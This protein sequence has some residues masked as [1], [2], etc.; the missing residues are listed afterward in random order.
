MLVRLV[1]WVFIRRLL[2]RQ[3]AQ[4]AP[5]AS[6]KSLPGKVHVILAPQVRFAVIPRA[7]HARKVHSAPLARLL[8]PY[9][10]R[11]SI[12]RALGS[13]FATTALLASIRRLPARQ[14]ALNV[15]VER[16]CKLRARSRMFV[17][18][19]H[20]GSILQSMLQAAHFVQ[21]GDT[22]R[23]KVLQAVRA[24][25]PANIRYQKVLR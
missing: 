12:R 7:A 22:K 3:I 14:A 21:L 13:L 24:V 20:K 4:N 9:A 23:D 19:V 16:F 10:Q 5:L 6:S 25:H 15:L 18:P 17:L 8:L 2:L 1:L 11:A